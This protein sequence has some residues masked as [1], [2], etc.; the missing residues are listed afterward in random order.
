MIRPGPVMLNTA[1]PEST[2]GV[3]KS[4]AGPLNNRQGGTDRENRKYRS[5]LKLFSLVRDHAIP[6]AVPT[7]DPVMTYANRST[8]KTRN[9]GVAAGIDLHIPEPIMIGG[10]TFTPSGLKA[11][12]AD[13]SA[14]LDAADALRQ[15]WRDQLVV[16]GAAG[17]TANEIH[18]YLRSYLRG[19]YGNPAYVIL[20]DFGMTPSKPA[21]PKT[22]KMKVVAADKRAATRVARHTM[23][24]NQKKGITGVTA[25]AATLREARPPRPR[26]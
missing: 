17:D 22:V 11:V 26:G 7:R 3:V 19:R 13:H 6:R 5:P 23:G 20:N 25:A 8:L 21:G 18:R 14:A 4:N 10:E 16:A 1:G 12:F 24:K 9:L 2:G 15:Q